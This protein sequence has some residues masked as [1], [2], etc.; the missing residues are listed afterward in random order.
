MVKHFAAHRLQQVLDSMGHMGMGE[1]TQTPIMSMLG[2]FL[3]MTVWRI[4]RVPQK[5]SALMVVSAP[6]NTKV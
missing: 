6:L 2:Y 4:L 5:P 1:I 3:L